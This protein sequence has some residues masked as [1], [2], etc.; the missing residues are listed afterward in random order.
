[1][2]MMRSD[3]Q[4]EQAHLAGERDVLRHR[5]TEERDPATGVDRR[6]RD[7]LHAVQVRREARDDHPPV[8][9]VAQDADRITG[10]TVVSDGVNPGRSALVESDRSSWTP[11][12]PISPRRPRSVVRPSTGREVELEVARVQDRARRRPVGHGERVRHRV[13]DRDELAVE[14][15]DR[16]SA[17]R[18]APAPSSVRPSRPASSMRL[19]AKPSDRAEP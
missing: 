12:R 7:L 10:P 8:G 14:R 3:A 16:R 19:R 2:S 17:R 13:R 15:A 5:P 11:S 9:V 18:R 1:M 4:R 6:D